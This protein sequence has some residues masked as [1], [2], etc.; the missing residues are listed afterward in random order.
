MA[1][2]VSES[3]QDEKKMVEKA[4]AAID[5]SHMDIVT[6]GSMYDFVCANENSVPRLAGVRKGSKLH[7]VLQ[8]LTE[9]LNTEDIFGNIRWE[10]LAEIKRKEDGAVFLYGLSVDA[11]H[12][13]IACMHSVFKAR[14]PKTHAKSVENYSADE[15][16]QYLRILPF[17][18]EQRQRIMA[19][20]EQSPEAVKC[21]FA[22][23]VESSAFDM[24]AAEDKAEVSSKPVPE[25]E[26]GNN[27]E[28]LDTEV[29]TETN[30][31]VA[32]GLA[33]EIN[34]QMEDGTAAE[35]LVKAVQETAES[36]T[37]NGYHLASMDGREQSLYFNST[38]A[39]LLLISYTLFGPDHPFFDKVLR[40]GCLKL[41]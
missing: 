35:L 11:I 9:D 2:F 5:I 33:K 26:M 20:Y 22:C 28:N 18:D 15:M 17:S 34:A 30:A 32:C 27:N 40:V 39:S 6:I 41:T 10:Q 31:D 25:C 4:R 7:Q 21:V 37:E 3:V 23:I 1:T 29:V 36:M 24:T 14:S 8:V 16:M 12:A 19:K 13:G 38:L